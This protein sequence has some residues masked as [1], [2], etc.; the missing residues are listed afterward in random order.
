MGNKETF[1]GSSLFPKTGQRKHTFTPPIQ[2]GN[3]LFTFS[4]GFVLN[5]DIQKM[6]HSVIHIVSIQ[7]VKTAR[8]KLEF[9]KF[10]QFK[11]IACNLGYGL[12][13]KILSV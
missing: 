7:T 8:M 9:F 4:D 3:M 2:G 1:K 5:L 11:D 6:H 13:H 12:F 10:V